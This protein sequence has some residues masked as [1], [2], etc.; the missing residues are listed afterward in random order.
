MIACRYCRAHLDAYLGGELTAPA[1]RRVAAHLDRCAACYS[2]YAQQRDLVRELRQALP[3]VGDANTP[4]FGQVWLHVQAEVPRGSGHPLPYGLVALLLALLLA[5]PFTMGHRDVPPA[6]PTQPA[7]Q[8]ISADPT[9]TRADVTSEAT[10]ASRV[11][12]QAVPAA[13]TPPTLPEPDTNDVPRG[14]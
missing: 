10:A 1:R 6:L 12:A 8:L 9:P 4:D 14:F 7:P 2:I 13:G 5:V 3:L 11:S